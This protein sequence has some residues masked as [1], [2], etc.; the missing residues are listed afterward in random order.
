MMSSVT[1]TLCAPDS[2]RL[3]IPLVTQSKGLAPSMRDLDKAVTV[4]QERQ[5]ELDARASWRSRARRR[6][7]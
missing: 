7:G 6:R 2:S 3:A 4:A 1:A 5:T